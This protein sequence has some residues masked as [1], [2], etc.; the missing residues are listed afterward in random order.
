MPKI[1]TPG[2]ADIRPLQLA[3]GYTANRPTRNIVHRSI[4]PDNAHPYL[5]L[6]AAGPR[7]GT[8]ALLFP[9]SATAHDCV[10]RHARPLTFTFTHEL[11]IDMGMVYAVAP[12]DITVELDPVGR[13][14]WVVSIPF[15]EL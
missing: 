4:D 7:T 10:A 11:Q 13:R 1:T 3:A 6:A 15:Q 8:L 14:Y 12:G 5:T 2:Y 9:D